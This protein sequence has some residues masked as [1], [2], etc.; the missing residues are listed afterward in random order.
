MEDSIS[1]GKT[2][3]MRPNGSNEDH[4]AVVV[5]EYFKLSSSDVGEERDG[6]VGDHWDTNEDVIEMTA[7][8]TNLVRMDNILRGNNIHPENG[9]RITFYPN[10]LK[11]E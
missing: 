7:V 8:M 9:G 4:T 5:D 1:V 10:T 6:Q 3:E 11:N 2:L